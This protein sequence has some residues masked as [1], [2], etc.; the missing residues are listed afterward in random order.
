M[1][2]PID[3]NA[4]ADTGKILELTATDMRAFQ[5][6][7][8]YAS[9]NVEQE[10]KQEKK[11]VTDVKELP[12]TQAISVQPEVD[13]SK[14][15]S[16]QASIKTEPITSTNTKTSTIGQI[17]AQNTASK[18]QSQAHTEHAQH[19]QHNKP[20]NITQTNINIQHIPN[21]ME[22][23]II[24]S[25]EKLSHEIVQVK[26]KHTIDEIVSDL[27]KLIH[28]LDNMHDKAYSKT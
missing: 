20:Q 10:K 21:D 16:A 1:D 17:I 15:K 14:I 22:K 26:L 19:S 6:Q 12:K 24:T 8:L 28:K 23:Q 18:Q 9:K 25:I 2:T 3:I 11:D 4:K 27:K 7:S 13:T 5:L